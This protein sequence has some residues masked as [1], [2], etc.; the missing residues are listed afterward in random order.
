MKKIRCY[1]YT[2]V[3]TSI[4][5]EGFSLKAQIDKIH[6]YAEYQNMEIVK[7]FSDEGKS[8]K[9]IAGRT[10]F[11]EMLSKIENR[12]DDISF[13]L[14]FKLSRFGRNASDVLNSLQIMQDYGV[15]L[16]CIEDGI[17]S[18]KDSGKLMI[19]VL[20]AVAE[21]ERENILVQTMAGRKQRAKEGKWN[22][23]FAP[24]GYNLI[25][26][27]LIVNEKEAE[28]VKII[29]EKYAYT[30]MGFTSIAN[31]LN[32]QGYKR[33]KRGTMK[34]EVFINSFI[35]GVIDNPVYNGKIAYGRR[36]A[37]KINGTR[38][39]YHTVKQKEYMLSDGIHAKIIDDDLWK[40]VCE[41]RK[42]TGVV[43]IK[44][45]FLDHENILSGILKCPVCGAGMYANH[46]KKATDKVD[47]YYYS[48]KH[49][50]MVGDSFCNYKKQWKQS[51]ID[52]AVEEFLSKLMKNPKLKE[53]L[54]KKINI[55][56][57]LT[58][59]QK[60]LENLQKT[61]KQFV[62][63]K[64]KLGIK[65]DN[66]DIDDKFYDEK[67]S[68]MEKR[69]NNLYEKIDDIENK[70]DIL[71][72]RIENIKKDNLTSESIY[73]ILECFDKLYY[74]FSDK[75]KKEFMKA[76]IEKIEIFEQ[77]QDNGC[78][79]KHIKFKFPIIYNGELCSEFSWDKENHVECVV[80]MSRV[81]PKK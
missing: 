58:E 25:N 12:E 26:G 9:N 68:D 3:S 10:A 2:R 23:G 76:F 18:S 17:D 22:G 41:K 60:E 43:Y 48:C 49:R 66:L 61:K 52:K 14:V 13:V 5:V 78:I 19:S 51:L 56:I 39:E 31:Y 69:L 64:D 77:Q 1:A 34:Y 74:K 16:I 7:E 71:N 28:I 45:H 30:T 55:N 72:Q 67:Y 37:E 4:Q 27:E 21:I 79:L 38:N 42:K 40:K 65:I 47:R 75:K 6:K 44:K 50:K 20:S 53:E 36:K 11:K 29:F 35:K 46:N 54:D 59:I 24:Y 62:G 32:H 80:L 73:R 81:N 63:A 57:D 33:E 15:N 70:I 8:G